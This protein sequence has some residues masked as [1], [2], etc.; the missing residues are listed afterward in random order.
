[1]SIAGLGEQFGPRVGREE[2]EYLASLTMLKGGS[3]ALAQ[4]VQLQSNWKIQ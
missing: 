2:G 3:V 1:M 4:V